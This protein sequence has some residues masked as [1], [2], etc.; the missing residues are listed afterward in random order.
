MRLR[1]VELGYDIP[2]AILQKVRFTDTR[3]FV[4]GQNLL[5]FTRYTGLDPDVMGN[6]LYER[7]VDNGDYPANR[8]IS[9]GIQFGF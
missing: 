7:G 6:G 3:I 1:H 2:Q 4:S 9:A 8:T 5:T